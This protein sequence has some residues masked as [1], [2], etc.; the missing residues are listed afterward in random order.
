[1]SHGLPDVT[2]QSTQHEVILHG[3]REVTLERQAISHDPSVTSMVLMVTMAGKH[4][5]HLSYNKQLLTIVDFCFGRYGVLLNSK[6][7]HVDLCSTSVNM[8]FT[9]Q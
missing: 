8:S 1:M 4:N 6:L 9:V 3:L 7:N 2:L 5:M